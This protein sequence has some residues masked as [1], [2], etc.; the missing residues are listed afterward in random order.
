MK[1]IYLIKSLL[2]FFLVLIMASCG[3]SKE[4]VEKRNEKIKE[5]K[6]ETLDSLNVYNREN[7]IKENNAIVG[8]DS[9]DNFTYTLQ[10]LFASESRPVS[11]RGEIKDIIKKD[12]VYIL[13]VYRE[14]SARSFRHSSN[15][16]AE[17]I[18]NS[19]TFLTLK[20]KLD[21][22]E[23]NTGC[24]I[25]N[26]TKVSSFNPVLSS[27]VEK[28]GENADDATS[29]LILDGDQTTIKLQGTLVAYYINQHVKNKNE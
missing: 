12:S 1:S 15:Y 2:S 17:I 23:Y 22:D 24:F 11:F 3:E 29:Y 5:D 16:I 18:V 25:F 7:I 28:N 4:E 13:K 27:E 26:V 14:S 6:Q 10:D 8:W 20:Q 9:T 21:P 19:N